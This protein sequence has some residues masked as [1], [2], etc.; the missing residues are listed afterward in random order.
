[1]SATEKKQRNETPLSQQRK[2]TVTAR[3][4]VLCNV[5]C[6]KRLREERGGEGGEEREGWKGAVPLRISVRSTSMPAPP[7]FFDHDAAGYAQLEGDVFP[8]NAWQM[9]VRMTQRWYWHHQ[10]NS[11]ASWVCLYFNATFNVV[12]PNF[13]RLCQHSR[14]T[15]EPGE[16]TARTARTY[17]TF[18]V[19]IALNTYPVR[20]LY[21]IAR[22]CEAD[23]IIIQLVGL[24]AHVFLWV[25]ALYRAQIVIVFVYMHR[26][27]MFV[28]NIFK[29]II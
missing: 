3:T 22:S 20:R 25:L 2:T 4:S 23:C 14:L 28:Q 21:S 15:G 5:Q 17:E 11:T 27:T 16:A 24:V 8:V 6:R 26:G 13:Q 9:R 29:D 10:Y 19:S 7:T 18:C 12:S 1:M